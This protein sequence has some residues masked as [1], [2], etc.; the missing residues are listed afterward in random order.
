[1]SE[2]GGPREKIGGRP[3]SKG[4]D[5][6]A[7]FFVFF[8]AGTEIRAGLLVQQTAGGAL[9]GCLKMFVEFTEEEQ[10]I[11]PHGYSIHGTDI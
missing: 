8:S 10:D 2:S 4:A 5:E 9:L 3:E 7:C 1:M 6:I 11:P